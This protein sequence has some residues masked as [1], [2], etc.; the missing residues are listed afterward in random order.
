MVPFKKQEN[1]TAG[2]KPENRKTVFNASQNNRRVWIKDYKEFT[3][4]KDHFYTD[5]QNS[6]HEPN[7]EL[8]EPIR[9][10]Q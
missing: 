1:Q 3:C 9:L 4:C 8:L 10:M 2:D 6:L 5:E 7:H